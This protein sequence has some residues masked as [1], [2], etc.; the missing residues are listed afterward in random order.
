M[1]SASG[2]DQL[3]IRTFDLF[4]GRTN[5][6][7]VRIELLR[8][9]LPLRRDGIGKDVLA[10]VTLAAVGIPQVMGY[11][12]IALT[13]LVTGLYTLLLPAAAF[14]LLGASRHLV[15]SADSAT[16]AIL[17]GAFSSLAAPGG[18]DYVRLTGL[19]ALSVA[20]M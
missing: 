7:I 10:G 8:G 18:P 16:A 6:G 1:G 12:K 2:T 19:A 14:A 17:A 11:T 13:P 5:G 4:P 15:V 3:V 9:I 20:G